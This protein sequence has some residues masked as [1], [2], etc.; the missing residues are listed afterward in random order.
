MIKATKFV[1][2]SK[3]TAKNRFK[4]LVLD[5]DDTEGE[6]NE[7]SNRNVQMEGLEV[8][9]KDVG[10]KKGATKGGKFKNRAEDRGR[11]KE[12]NTKIEEM[13]L[14]PR[15]GARSPQSGGESW[16]AMNEMKKIQGARD[17]RDEKIQGA[18]DEKFQ[19][20]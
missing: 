3:D 18:R 12:T 1:K 13:V 16:R 5:P 14:P 2:I 15:L 19:G 6:E 17:E 10:G 20:V 9:I 8:Y 7:L 4:I 11:N